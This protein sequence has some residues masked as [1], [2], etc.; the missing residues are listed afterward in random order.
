MAK[1]TIELRLRVKGLMNVYGDSQPR[2]IHCVQDVAYPP[3]SL[4]KWPEK[5]PFED[6]CGRL[7]FITQELAEEEIA[8]IRFSLSDSQN[9]VAGSQAS[10][11]ACPFPT[12]CWLAHNMGRGGSTTF[13]L[14]GWDVQPLRL[15]N[16]SGR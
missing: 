3:T 9:R 12:R 7:V 16:N 4:A 14:D 5:S 1:S 2:V 15:R 6:H 10:S 11:A 13:K 8:A